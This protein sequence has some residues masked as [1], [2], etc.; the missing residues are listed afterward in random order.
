MGDD[1]RFTPLPHHIFGIKTMQKYSINAFFFQLVASGIL[2]YK[3]VNTN[4]S[5]ACELAKDDNDHFHYKNKSY[6]LGFAF[7]KNGWGAGTIS[8]DDVFNEQ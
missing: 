1:G 8:Y 3:W 4:T 2:T 6:W 5:V 7:Q